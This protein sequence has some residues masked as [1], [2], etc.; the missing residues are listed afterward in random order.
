[1]VSRVAGRIVTGPAAFFAAWAI[2]IS[3]FAVSGIQRRLR[4]P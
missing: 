1:M 4:R 2:D 3:V